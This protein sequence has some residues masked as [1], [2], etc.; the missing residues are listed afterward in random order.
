MADVKI[1]ARDIEPEA[2]AQ[3]ASLAALPPFGP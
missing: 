2:A 3:V 1:F